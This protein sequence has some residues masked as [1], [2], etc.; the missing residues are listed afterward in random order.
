MYISNHA[1]QRLQQRAL[2]ERDLDLIIAHGTETTDGYLLRRKDVAGIEREL[3][4]L[5]ECLHKLEGIFVVVKGETV[6]TAYYS[7]QK[8]QKAILRN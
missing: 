2:N 3:K 4:A 8:K 7:R 6:V 5:I 1:Q